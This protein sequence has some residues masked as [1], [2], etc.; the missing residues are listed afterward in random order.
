MDYN[1]LEFLE[2]L[3]KN[4]TI[5]EETYRREREQILAKVKPI[6]QNQSQQYWGMSESSYISLMH[7]SQFGGFIFPF[8]GFILPIVMWLTNKDTNA[9]IDKHGKNIVNFMISYFIYL[10]VSCVLILVLIGIPMLILLGILG[11]VFI[12][13]ATIKSSKGEYWEY[14]LAIRFIR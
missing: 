11:I 1:D 9:N 7:L 13:V 12:I 5:S 2:E 10:A 14:P 6:V 3:R 4:G 8:L